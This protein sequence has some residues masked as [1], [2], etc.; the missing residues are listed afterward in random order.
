MN[1]D[2]SKLENT[3]THEHN[4]EVSSVI[5]VAHTILF[6]KNNVVYELNTITDTIKEVVNTIPYEYRIVGMSFF[7]DELQIVTVFHE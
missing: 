6:S 7:N 1:W 3:I 5:R 4:Y 2:C